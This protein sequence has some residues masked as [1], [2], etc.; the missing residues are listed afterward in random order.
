MIAVVIAPAIV[1]RMIEADKIAINESSSPH[2]HDTS[3]LPK[4]GQKIGFAGW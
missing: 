2:L 1:A 3:R 4:R